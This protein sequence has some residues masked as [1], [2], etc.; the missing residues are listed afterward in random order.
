MNK[1]N[2]SSLAQRVYTLC[3]RITACRSAAAAIAV[4]ALSCDEPLRGAVRLSLR[5]SCE[6][7]TDSPDQEP[8]LRILSPQERAALLLLDSLHLPP[9]DA[10]RWSEI[11]EHELIGHAHRARLKLAKNA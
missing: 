9:A 11:P 5:Q 3:Y 4:E 10:A 6:S 1:L 8:L 7:D 2:H